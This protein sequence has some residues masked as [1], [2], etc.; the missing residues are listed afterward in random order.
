MKNNTLCINNNNFN[1]E[2]IEQSISLINGRTHFYGSRQTTGNW[3][4]FAREYF[5][6]K[7]VA[8]FVLW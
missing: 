8:V 7:D 3:R 5:L 4:P 1:S 6:N 2:F